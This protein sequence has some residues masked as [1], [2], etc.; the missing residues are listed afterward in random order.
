[1]LV[2]L[3]LKD[4]P[5]ILRD[6]PIVFIAY[7]DLKPL[8]AEILEEDSSIL[9][10][11]LLTLYKYPELMEVNP[12]L[13]PILEDIFEKTDDSYAKAVFSIIQ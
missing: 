1:M 10:S 13:K 2:T 6:K 3:A 5:C 11:D 12:D 9:G 8:V 4:Y 7:P